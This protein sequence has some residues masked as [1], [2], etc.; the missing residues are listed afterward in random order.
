MKFFKL[1]FIFLFSTVLQLNA[2]GQQK[3]KVETIKLT[4]QLYMLIGQGGNIGVF[5]SDDGIFMIDDQYE[6]M[7]PKLM[8]AVAKISKQPIKFLLNTHWHGDHSGGNDNFNKEETVLVAHENVRK[9]MSTEQFNK[10]FSRK[11]PPSPANALPEITF[12]ED[13][14]FYMG[15]ETIMVFHLHDA[16]TDG[17]AMVYFPNNNVLHI[18]DVVFQGKYPFIDVSSGGSVDGYIAAIKK[19]LLLINDD[20]IIIPGHKAKTNKAE[21]KEYL[22]MLEYVRAGVLEKIK[23]G[24]T[25]EEVVADASIT[26]KYDDLD[27]GSWFIKPNVIRLLLYRSLTK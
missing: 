6:H 17:D 26:K 23:E 7:S 13:L 20:T 22:A 14:T 27:Y 3:I 24:K 5:V 10:E 12:T 16:H 2:Q 21:L 25:E 1:A 4:D 8:E 18:G 9:R 19:A 11:T 15:G